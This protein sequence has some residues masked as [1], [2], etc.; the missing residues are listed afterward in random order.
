MGGPAVVTDQLTRDT[1]QAGERAERVL[2]LRN[3]SKSFGGLRAL[4]DVSFH[5]AKGEV[6]GLLGDNGAGKSTLVKCLSGIHRPDDGE[7]LVDGTEVTLDSV[8]TAQGLGIETVYQGLALVQSLDVASNLFLNRELLTRRLGWLGWLD[9]R[10]M[11]REAES[12]LAGLGIRIPSARAET[13]TLSGG[14]RQ[15]IAIGRAVAWGRHI[16]LLDEPAA[17]L[18][19]EQSL[20]V[21]ELIDN[22]R[23]RGVAVVLVSHNM[24][25][26]RQICDRAVVLRHGHKVADVAI[27]DV[28]ERDLIHHI[29]GGATARRL[30]GPL[31]TTERKQQ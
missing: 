24:Q 15:A 7:I 5:L 13:V 2:E 1:A 14:Q 8:P 27:A 19:V 26:V 3:L 28:T 21:L 30:G 4:V 9:Q 18:G 16:V 11:Y 25:H 20:H 23:R 31:A 22:L 10:R 12:I 29:A 6:L 17:A